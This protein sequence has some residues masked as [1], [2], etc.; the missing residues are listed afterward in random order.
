MDDDLG[1]RRS[2]VAAGVLAPQATRGDVQR[3][4]LPMPG[5]APAPSSA[6]PPRDDTGSRSSRSASSRSKSK[7]KP[8]ATRTDTAQGPKVAK[9]DAPAPVIGPVKKVATTVGEKLSTKTEFTRDQWERGRA[10]GEVLGSIWPG[11]ITPKDAFAHAAEV[12]QRDIVLPPSVNVRDGITPGE[13]GRSVVGAFQGQALGLA[14]GLQGLTQNAG[15]EVAKATAQTFG[16]MPS[17]VE[18]SARE[19]A[20]VA[21]DHEAKKFQQGAPSLR[22]RAAGLLPSLPGN[23]EREAADHA[24]KPEGSPQSEALAGA[25]R[26]FP[27]DG[28]GDEET[29]EHREAMGMHVPLIGAS[30]LQPSRSARATTRVG[31]REVASDLRAPPRASDYTLPFVRG[32]VL[33][34][35]STVAPAVPALPEVPTMSPDD[36]EDGLLGAFTGAAEKV[37]ST[38]ARAKEFADENQGALLGAAGAVAGA[39]LIGAAVTTAVKTGA[40]AR[41]ASA[42]RNAVSRRKSTSKAATSKKTGGKLTRKTNGKAK[43]AGSPGKREDRS[44]VT[45]STYRG[46]P[47]YR[48]KGRAYVIRQRAE[49]TA[50]GH[51]L[52]KGSWK[53]IPQ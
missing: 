38:A 44:G 52:P 53:F 21:G 27:Q 26:Y 50:S 19:A 16:L 9:R 4:D 2:R 51:V 17:E 28:K 48:H 36:S 45:R 12:G 15:A 6:A 30:N 14:G 32:R 49:R 20:A 7:S 34:A 35:P 39:G 46:Q 31:G 23:P 8:K 11:G 1:D 24:E 29:A 47:V 25:T 33:D 42:V 37:K 10:A 40:A 41:A 13:A 43:R 3:S 5:K 18:I 22:D